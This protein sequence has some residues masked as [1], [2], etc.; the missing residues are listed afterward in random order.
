MIIFHEVEV[1]HWIYKD[2]VEDWEIFIDGASDRT[3]EI[4][5]TVFEALAR[6]KNISNFSFNER[7]L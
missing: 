2:G 4:I 3:Y 1:V 6:I 7:I 5:S